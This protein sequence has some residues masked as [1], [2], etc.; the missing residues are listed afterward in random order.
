MQLFV[1]RRSFSYVVNFGSV[2]FPLVICSLSVSA[3]DPRAVADR[4]SICINLLLA[5]AALKIGVSYY[6]S[7]S[8]YL[9]TLD[10]YI[11]LATSIV[12]FV[13]L[14]NILVSTCLLSWPKSGR[15]EHFFYGSLVT[16][17]VGLH[18]LI[19]V[20]TIRGDMLRQPWEK[21]KER[22]RIDDRNSTEGT[23]EEFVECRELHDKEE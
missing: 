6:F 14:E 3:I 13:L 15:I 20:R 21:V 16:F 9:T 4:I 18:S 8:H 23:Y 5:L 17:W 10:K 7:P 12:A 22:H 11:L 2:V 19:I 1:E